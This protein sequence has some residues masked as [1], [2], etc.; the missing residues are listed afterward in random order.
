M[1]IEMFIIIIILLCFI[2]Y[3]QFK[4]VGKVRELN[5]YKYQKP[6]DDYD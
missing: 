5:Y 1:I 4:L 2:A 6:Y 3:Q